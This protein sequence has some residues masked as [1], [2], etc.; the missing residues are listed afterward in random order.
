[1]DYVTIFATEEAEVAVHSL[2]LLLVGQLAIFSEFRGDIKLVAV[3]K[4][5]GESSG[6]VQ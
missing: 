2:L 5:G 1:M 6:V 4:A 3:G